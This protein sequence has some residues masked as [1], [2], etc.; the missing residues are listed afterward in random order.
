MRSVSFVCAIHTG[1]PDLRFDMVLGDLYIS[2]S[3]ICSMENSSVLSQ[4]GLMKK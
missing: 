3:M 4:S 1:D 2:L